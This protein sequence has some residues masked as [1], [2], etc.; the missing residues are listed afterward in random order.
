MGCHYM[1][2]PFWA[3]KLRHPTTVEAEGP[4]L[5]PETAPQWIIVRYE[6][7][8]REGLPPVKFTWYDGG[9]R[10]KLFAEKKLP[11]W[12]DGVLFIGKEG[13]LIAD[14]D[15]HVLLPEDKFR[16]YKRPAPYI[17]SSVG[18][19][20]EWITAC[21]TGSPTTCNFNYSG[22]LSE[23]VLLGNVAFR[24]GKRLEW[25]A[26]KLKASNYPEADKFLAREYRKGW[27]LT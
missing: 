22:A 11:E 6:F 19:Y 8:E 4:P 13:M 10:P 21:K 23:A 25:D 9:K 5:N 15:R 7:P 20:A 17:P 26:E 16:D 27:S 14:Y 12:G 3:L 1:D 24:S 2:L 18:H